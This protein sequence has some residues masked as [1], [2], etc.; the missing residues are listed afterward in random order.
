MIVVFQIQGGKPRTTAKS[1]LDR[2][3]STVPQ[4]PSNWIIHQQNN[5]IR[6]N[7]NLCETREAP[8]LTLH[9]TSRNALSGSFNSS[10]TCRRTASFSAACASPVSKTPILACRKS[11]EP[12]RRLRHRYWRRFVLDPPKFVEFS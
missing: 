8:S 11:E 6:R 2:V 10:P 1:H 3:L 12:T 9:S 5:S 7:C 4:M